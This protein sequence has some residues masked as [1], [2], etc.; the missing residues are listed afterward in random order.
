MVGPSAATIPGGEAQLEEG[1]SNTT[2][3]AGGFGSWRGTRL[4][5][6]GI[7]PLQGVSGEVGQALG[8]QQTSG[9]GFYHVVWDTLSQD[10]TIAWAESLEAGVLPLSCKQAL[11]PKMGDH[12]D[13]GNWRP[14]SLLGTEYKAIAKATA[15]EVHAG[16]CDLSSQTYAVPAWTIFDNLSGLGPSPSGVE[17]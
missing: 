6:S 7:H 11:L 4:L 10:L 16:R 5:A 1:H 17:G 9:L 8:P 14:V 3:G 12:N 2:V 15:A 13:L